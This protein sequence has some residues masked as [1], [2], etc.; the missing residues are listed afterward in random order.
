MRITYDKEADAMYIRLCE[1]KVSKTKEIDANTIVDYDEEGNAIGIEILFVRERMP[2]LLK[3]V[4]VE[5]LLAA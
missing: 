2:H 3:E 5:N 1:A 4:Q